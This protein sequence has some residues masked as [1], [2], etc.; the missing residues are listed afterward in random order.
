MISVKGRLDLPKQAT[1]V[2]APFREKADQISLML[3]LCECVWG[4]TK[5]RVIGAQKTGEVL[6]STHWYAT[7]CC[8]ISHSCPHPEGAGGGRGHMPQPGPCRFCADWCYNFPVLQALTPPE[9]P[10]SPIC[11]GL[12]PREKGPS[13]FPILLP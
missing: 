5:G 1:G 9:N 8:T 6:L 11:V 13:P 12:S 10:T 3:A 4:S 2:T 7:T